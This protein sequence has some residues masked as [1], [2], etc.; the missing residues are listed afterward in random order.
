MPAEMTKR[1]LL[2]DVQSQQNFRG[3]PIQSVGVTNIR[4]PFIFR[5]AST[6]QPTVGTWGLFVSLAG[7]KRGTHMSRF[8]EVLSGLDEVLTVESLQETCEQIRSRLV[9]GDA[10]ISIEFPWFVEKTAPVSG[11]KGKLDID[12]LIEISLGSTNDLMTEYT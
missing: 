5:S 8:M 11:A 10:S 9:A 3:R 7:D 12:V 4:H 1:E 2:D 6:T